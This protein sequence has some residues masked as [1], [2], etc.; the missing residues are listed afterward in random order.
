[1][2][3]NELARDVGLVGALTVG[4]GA[5]LGAGIFVLPSIVAGQVGPI[6]WLPFLLAGCL[7]LVNAVL[8]A[9]LATALPRSGGSYGWVYRALGP[10][11]GTLTGI[12]NWTSTALVTAFYCLGF[13]IYLGFFIPLPEGWLFGLTL[14]PERTGAVLAAFVILA[15][16]Y[17]GVRNGG[18][19]AVAL[20]CLLVAS[21]VGFVVATTA[22]IGV[23]ELIAAVTD[24]R[25]VG[26]IDS[27]AGATALVFVSYLGYA[28]LAAIAGEVQTPGWTLPR[29]ILGSLLAVGTLYVCIAI[30]LEAA[31][32]WETL[33]ATDQAIV[34]VAD[35]VSGSAG[36]AIVGLAGILATV[37][38]AT[39][40]ISTSARIGHAMGSDGL[41]SRSLGT[42]HPR[43]G[44]PYRAFQLT[45]LVV[46][47]LVVTA[48]LVTLAL[49]ATA[50]HLVVAVLSSISLLSVRRSVPS[51]EPPFEAPASAALAVIACLG[52]IALLVAVGTTVLLLTT[53]VLVG[54]IG[55][56]VLYGRTRAAPS[57]SIETELERRVDAGPR[58][59]KADADSSNGVETGT[60]GL[61]RNLMRSEAEQIDEDVPDE[62]ILIP[63]SNPRTERDLVELGCTVAQSRG[64]GV[65]AIH[66]VQ[67]PSQTPLHQATGREHTA[68]DRLLEAAREHAEPF[69]VPLETYTVFSHRSVEEV[70]DA[71]RRH[72]ADLVVMGWR[73]S[74]P[75]AG[76]AE[77]VIDELAHELPADLLVLNDRGFDPSSVLLPTTGTVNDALGAEIARVFC[78]VCESDV[79]LLH[80]VDG[81][82]ER[83]GGERF[84]EDWSA[85]HDLEDAATVVDTS[86]DVEG[87]ISNHAADH[88][89]LIVGATERGLL[90]RLVKRALALG[91]VE[92]VECSVLLTE[93]AHRRSL[94][95]RLFR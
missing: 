27:L 30:V 18:P 17:V 2:T 92:D 41:V 42:L 87:A 4:I 71:A 28:K 25:L 24:D 58:A 72:E 29:A 81:E 16:N 19:G 38:S 40:S 9:E 60:E 15:S 7:A 73:E 37:T 76:R 82:R 45:G 69:D 74:T 11:F 95:E 94:R 86:G 80:V 1:M 6:L 56:F 57:D 70:F 52:S 46:V 31:V 44:T 8:V 36:V 35:A 55:W 13:G 59:P 10:P 65:V 88:S 23:G 5:T 78:D 93:R 51:Y 3:N 67:V 90:S 66:I 47:A 62:T 63:L 64:A 39:M 26:S 68:S 32:D 21:L 84:L 61:S 53:A 14:S 34:I 49:L 83:G 33:A 79:T 89:L 75:F 85:R 77:T 50:L 91:V 48:D 54:A 12:A 43:F 22:T 20:V